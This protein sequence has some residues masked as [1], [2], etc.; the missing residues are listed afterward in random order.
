MLGLFRTFTWSAVILFCVTGCAAIGGASVPVALIPG[1][2]TV[3]TVLP[4]PESTPASNSLVSSASLPNPLAVR[5]PSGTVLGPKT[6]HQV[7]ALSTL[8]H[9]PSVA[10]LYFVEDGQHLAS[11]GTAFSVKLWDAATAQLVG[12]PIDQAGRLYTVAFSPDGTGLAT[13]DWRGTIELWD[14]LSG[15]VTRTLTG[16]GGHLLRLAF[17]P[18]GT[19]LASA[20][21]DNLVKLWDLESGQEIRTLEG[22]ITPV[23]ALAFSPDGSLLASGG[24]KYSTVVKLWD[25]DSGE[26]L[27]TLDGHADNL[28]S[29]LFSPDGELLASASA[30]GMLRLRTVRDGR[31]VHTLTGQTEAVRCLAFSPDGA[32]LASSADNGQITL[33]DVESGTELRRLNGHREDVLALAFSPDGSLLASGGLDDDVYVW[34]IPQEG[35]SAGERAIDD[36][37]TT[38]GDAPPTTSPIQASNGVI[39]FSSYR[40]GESKIFTLSADG[41]GLARLSSSRQRDTRPAWSPDGTRLAFVRRVSHSDHEIY[42]MKADGTEVTRLTDRPHSVESEPAWS[43]DGSRIAFIS[44]ER[45]TVNTLYGRFHVWLM[46]ADG[47]GLMLLTDIGGG[48]TSPT[49]SPDGTRLAFDSTR[50][51]DHEIYVIN[52]DGSHPVNLSQHPAHDTSPSWS[53]DG[54]RIAFVSDRDGNQE[55]YVMDADGSNQ[56]RLTDQPGYDK[57]PVWSPDGR[58]LVFYS[59]AAAN[60]TDLYQMRADGSGLVRLTRDADFDGFPTWQPILPT[61]SAKGDAAPGDAGD[62]AVSP[63]QESLGAGAVPQVDE[64]SVDEQA[65]GLRDL[66]IDDFFEQSFA[67]LMRRDPEWITTEGLMEQM[68]TGNDRLTDISDDYIRDTQALQVAI[69]DLLREYDRDALMPEQQVSVDVYGWYLD[70][71]VRGQEFMYHDYPVTHFTTGVQY[72]LLQFFTDIHPLESRQDIEGYV[73]RLY[74]VS[75]KF[76]GLVEGLRKREEAGVILPGFIFPWLMRDIRS[77]AHSEPRHTPFY[78]TLE[79]KIPTVEDLNAED[80]R[81]LLE[82]AELAIEQSVIPAFSALEQTLG[83]LES[84][85]PSEGGVGQLP[86]GDDYYDHVLRHHT[87]TDMSA[88]EIHRLGL[89][90]LERIQAEMRGI[91]TELGYPEGESIPDLYARLARESGSVSGSRVAGEY[92]AIIDTAEQN[93]APAFDI[94]P[95]ADLIV[96][97]GGQGDYYVSASLDGKRPGAFYARVDGS[98]DLYAMPTLAYHEAIPGH[99]FQIALAQESDLPLFRNVILFTGYA[100]GWALYAEQ[101]AYELGWYEDDPYGNL[102]RLRDQAFR[103]A[104]LV[105][106]TGLHA[107]GWTFDQALEFMV[108]NVGRDPGLL[109]FEVTRYIAWPGQA[110]AYMVGMLKIMNLRQLAMEKLGEQFDLKE[111]HHVVLA[112]GSMPLEVLE[113]VVDGYIEEKLDQ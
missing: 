34:G 31:T 26:D 9:Y 36:I 109:Q 111:F 90:E 82:E 103:A 104:R 47:S 10:A 51:G 21:D 35:T 49:W 59:R 68:G 13:G 16:H 63:E 58:Y 86:D 92:E 24:I 29:L 53:P 79:A 101:L 17:S 88:E 40:D 23:S 50:D 110:T 32:L 55:I 113:R 54:R 81:A 41:S 7:E 69:L 43:P 11:V 1:T 12:S 2:R 112:N 30:D 70:D 44:N 107:K 87:T 57:S 19:L 97:A 48:N 98:T 84:V 39:A 96:I 8:S 15:E 14:L 75:G 72:Q 91:F 64:R 65:A 106:D 25:V 18:D 83:H 74:Q 56:A 38:P 78:T 89:R 102:G 67:L 33:W 77:I 52:A 93:L 42:V 37:S 80:R 62:Q 5:A 28:Q 71:L 45:P 60:N 100:E 94:R 99:H 73:A 4:A 27:R 95:S 108:E 66:A 61:T 6:I 20:G 105:V 3:P 22:H 85:A 46:N 76:E